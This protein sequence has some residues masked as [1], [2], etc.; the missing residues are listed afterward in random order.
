[1]CTCG[2]PFILPD[3]LM[4]TQLLAFTRTILQPNDKDI[5][6]EKKK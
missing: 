2:E 5:A 4:D 3:H 1:M 6:R